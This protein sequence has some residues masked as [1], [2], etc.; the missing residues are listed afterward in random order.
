MKRDEIDFFAVE[1]HQLD[2]HDDLLNWAAWVNPRPTGWKTQPMFRHYRSHAWQWHEPEIKRAI[3]AI[4][5]Q[6]ME[7]AVGHLPPKNRDAVRWCYVFC[8]SPVPIAR[9]LGVSKQGLFDL[10]RNGRQ[11]L[12]NTRKQNR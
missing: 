4:A 10:I 9:E 8:G 12:I 6:Y 5:G 1:S 2:I 11:M 7:K 3:D